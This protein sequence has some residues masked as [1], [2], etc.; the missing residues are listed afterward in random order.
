MGL[1]LSHGDDFYCAYSTWE[2]TVKTIEKFIVDDHTEGLDVLLGTS[3]DSEISPKICRLIVQ[4]LMMVL[5]NIEF[6]EDIQYWTMM[7]FIIACLDAYSK[8]ETLEF[9]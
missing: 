6:E 2:K 5:P 4:D 7:R 1:H 8:N 3:P 9:I